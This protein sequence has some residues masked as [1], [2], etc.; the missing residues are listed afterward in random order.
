MMQRKLSRDEPSEGESRVSRPVESARQF[1]LLAVA[2]ELFCERGY[3]ATTMNDIGAAAGMSGP[4]IYRHFPG[5]DDLLRGAMYSLSR[6]LG[7]SVDEALDLAGPTPSEKL[8]ALVTAYV[9]CV[10]EQRDFASVYLFETR[11][12]HEEML[13]EFRAIESAFHEQWSQILMEAQP[14]LDHET[15]I[16]KIRAVTFLVG[17]ITLDEPVLDPSSLQG[18][19]VSSAMKALT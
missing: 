8:R 19:L 5:K 12:I 16:T 11:H 3:H 17:S 6:N 9:K 15:A 18:V 13:R 2:A 4:A 7:E 14:E 1:E 10:V